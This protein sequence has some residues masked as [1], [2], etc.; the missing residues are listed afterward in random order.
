MVIRKKR[1]K[2]RKFIYVPVAPDGSYMLH[3][4][5][6]SR[7]DAIEHLRMDSDDQY[8]TWEAYREHGYRIATLERP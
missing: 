5:A 3:L 7:V 4:E 1:S 8:P 6:T 2:P